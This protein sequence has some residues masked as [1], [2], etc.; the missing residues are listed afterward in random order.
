MVKT[1]VL[2]LAFLGLFLPMAAQ[3]P[4]AGDLPPEGPPPARR[5]EMAKLYLVQV[6]RED[7]AL[8]DAQTLKVMAV[9][10]QLDEARKSHQEEMSALL[11]KLRTHAEDPAVSDATLKEDVAQFR[12]AQPRFEASLRDLEGKLLDILTPRQQA[13]YLV[14]RR[15]L[16]AEIAGGG[17]NQGRGPGR[18]P[19]AS[20]R[21]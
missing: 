8:T 17:A 9:L 1:G 12:A 11:G 3:E 14:L 10:D 21:R 5:R 15:D 13:R 19:G 4:P 18:G 20:R 7:L 2:A 16:M 6:M